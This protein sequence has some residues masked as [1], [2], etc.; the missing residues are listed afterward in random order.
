MVP[1]S[2]KLLEIQTANSSKRIRYK[3]LKEINW[4][5]VKDRVNQFIAASVYKFILWHQHIWPIFLLNLAYLEEQLGL[6]VSQ[7]LFC[8]V[9]LMAMDK[10]VYLTYNPVQNL[11]EFWEFWEF[12][13]YFLNFSYLFIV[14]TPPSASPSPITMLLFNT[15]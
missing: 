2:N 15:I 11:W 8:H 6:L 4:L 14:F 3:H 5:P 13:S 12:S 9:E 1:K 7:I 10:I